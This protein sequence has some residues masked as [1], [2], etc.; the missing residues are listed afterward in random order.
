[1]RD[2]RMAR[3]ALERVAIAYG[4][5]LE[6]GRAVSFNAAPLSNPIFDRATAD[7]FPQLHWSLGPAIQESF[8]D[9]SAPLQI[10]VLAALDV[11]LDLMPGLSIVGRGEANVFNSYSFGLPSD[12]QLPHVR[13]DTQ[14]YFRHG[15]NGIAELNAIYRMRITPDVYLGVKAGYLESQFAGV[16]GQILWRPDDS[17]FSF[18]VDAYE[19]WQRN[20][21][22]LFGLRDYHVFT[23][24]A[25]IYYESPWYGLNFAVHAGRYLAGDYGATFE[26]TRRFSTGIEV[27]AFAT[28]TNV[29]FSQFGEGSFDK[30][31]VI[32]IPLE[33]A[34]PFYTQSAYD[35]TLRSLQRDGGARLVG[36]DF[37]FDD[38]KS[39]S[40]GEV[41]GHIDEVTDP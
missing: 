9:P 37:L 3:S 31:I 20:F 5:P 29:P 39:T 28:F 19:V 27:G 24:H 12:S 30:G 11:T 41:L 17:R 15:L 22:R 36:D 38:T 13:S 21:D 25:S 16:G 34:L 32:H 10:E 1:M 7:T 35:L 14:E 4:T 26:V 8:F 23:G 40:Y 2:F 18:G 6:V 33:W